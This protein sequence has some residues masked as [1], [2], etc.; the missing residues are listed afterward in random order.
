MNGDKTIRDSVHGNIRIEGLFLELM[1]LPEMQRLHGIRQLGFTY[2]VYPGAN[3][4]RLEHSLGTCYVARRMADSLGLK[5]METDRVAAAAFLH[6]VG[7]GPFSHTL[8]YLMHERVGKDHVEITR[9]MIAGRRRLD[10]SE[11]GMK[12]KD[13]LG[14]YGI[15]A[16]DIVSILSGEKGYLSEIIHGP[17]DADQVDYL[18]RDAHYT[19][20]AYGVID[21]DRL[22]QTIKIHDGHVVAEKKGVS[23]I[24]SMLVA[25]SL[26]YSSV[27]LHKTVRIAE[28]MLVR[29]VERA[30]LFDF[31]QMT[32]GELMEHMKGMGKF[33][34]DIALR[35][36]YRRLFKRA[37]TMTLSELKKEEKEYLAHI[38]VGKIEDEIAEKAGLDDGYVIVDVPGRDILLSEPRL[39]KMDVKILDKGDVK[40]LSE[41]TPLAN[42]L[43]MRGI[44]DWGI[45]VC[46]P[47]KA[48]EKVAKIAEKVLWG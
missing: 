22:M 16:W 20:V 34:R 7:H 4:T 25:R 11:D 23:A 17:V 29:A 41:Y 13:V 38:K 35:L 46:C 6:D 14:R 39:R 1:G 36:K 45:M 8:E 31:S 26:M 43:Q 27:Y 48:R 37:Y 15:D 3:H 12:I 47:E 30:E 19:G 5:K 42:A 21:F 40:P 28:L 10:D 2:L 24:E 33:Q 32:D 9:E 18:L 44:T